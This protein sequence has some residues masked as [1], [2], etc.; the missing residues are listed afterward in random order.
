MSYPDVP[1][2]RFIDLDLIT[3]QCAQDTL[4]QIEPLVIERIGCVLGA[5]LDSYPAES[6]EIA[7]TD[8]QPR[9]P[10]PTDSGVFASTDIQPGSQGLSYESGRTLLFEIT[11][12]SQGAPVRHT[13]P[14]DSEDQADWNISPAIHQ[15]QQ[16]DQHRQ[17]QHT[18]ETVL[19]QIPPE[20]QAEFD[21]YSVFLD[22]YEL[23]SVPDTLLTSQTDSPRNQAAGE[24]SAQTQRNIQSDILLLTDPLPTRYHT[25]QTSH[26]REEPHCCYCE[27]FWT[28]Q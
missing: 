10:Y 26:Y 6:I 11:A 9:S 24:L 5:Y 16:Y 27:L 21:V 28:H 19:L 12:E 25:D 2:I 17:Q 13:L 1:A 3:N 18:S 23:Q 7:S 15:N 14:R 8:I 4:S 20:L 22:N